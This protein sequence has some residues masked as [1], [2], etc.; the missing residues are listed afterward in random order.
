M[1]KELLKRPIG[2]T[3]SVIAIVVL[4]IVAM[5][6]LPVSLMPDID[7]PQ[8]TIQVSAPGLSVREVD[9]TLLKPL[10]NQLS[11]VEGLKNITAE[12]RADAG[13]IYMDFEPN[14]NID[15]I[16]IEVNEKLDRA[17]TTLPKDVERPKVI[18]ASVTDIPAFYLNL[19]LKSGAPREPGKPREAGIDF[20]ELGQF[21]RDVIAK[22]IEQLP[23]TAMVDISGVVTPELLCIPD[24]TKLTSMGVGIGLLENAI[25]DN[26]VSL[27][28]LS[29]KDGQY[30]YS[31]HFD[32][33]IISK[34]D[35]ENIYINHD[36][37]IYRF[38]E[39]CEIVERPA[40]RNGLVRSG[41]DPAV[42]LAIIKQSDA[43][44]A[45]LQES[46]AALITDLEKEHPDIRFELTR[47]QTQ[48]LSYSI[49]NLN[50]NLLVGAVLAALIIFLFM[51][52]L[53][54]PVLIVIT[55]PLS[56]VITLLVFH[57]LG[58]SL[59]IISLSGL[60]LGTGMIV[61]NSII[62][63]D[64]IFQKWRTGL[65]LEDSIARAV[66]EVF[67]PMLSSVLTTCSVFLPLIFLSGTAGALF[68][69]QAM[70]VTVALFASLLAAVLVLPVYFYLMYRKLS[71]DTENR[72]MSKL[73]TFNYY[74][75]YELGLKWVLRHGRLMMICFILFTGWWRKA[76]FPKY[77]MTIR[78]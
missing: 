2:V 58:M 13:A 31:I 52:D 75:P 4:S 7:I 69:D 67:T 77:P 72:F 54:S 5:G 56:L 48:L 19:S 61:D 14:G 26:N 25:A 71:P 23:Q 34:E 50:S 27:G 11:Q 24:Y 9:N 15:L 59:N 51:K 46:I 1:I 38:K 53:R 66:G 73:F 68:Y 10:K 49:H 42:T 30:R 40:K 21:A 28:A 35:I 20:S 36:G 16:F 74:R 65:T 33:R 18:K 41:A 57:V 3:M 8:I 62:V 64:N 76:G 44:M 39:L 37:R 55:I 45:D 78:S 32:S 29:I 22:R 6:Y 43:R 12:A 70:A 60:I 17:V 63:I 47:D